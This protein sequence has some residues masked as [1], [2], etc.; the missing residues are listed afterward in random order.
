[1]LLSASILFAGGSSTKTLRIL[2][3]MGVTTITGRTY[4]LHQKHV[5]EP[6]LQHQWEVHQSQLLTELVNR[7]TPLTLGGD[8]RAD[9][10]G[11]SAKYGVYSVKE[12]TINKVIDLQLVQV[13]Q[14]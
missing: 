5:L 3:H 6:S 12:L 1:M 2:Q 10:P 4:S 8:G 11:H 7:G 14:A 13:C 9:S